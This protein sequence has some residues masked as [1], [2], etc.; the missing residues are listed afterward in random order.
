MK[1][2]LSI[3]FIFLMLAACSNVKGV[4][5][6]EVEERGYITV[7]MEGTW[8]PWTYHDEND[9]LVGFDVE[10]GK[11]IADYL[12]VDVKYVEGE[13]NGLLAG[14]ADGRYDMVINGIDVDEDRKKTYDFSAPYAY[15]RIAVI[16]TKD[17]NSI[18]KMEDLNGKKTA[19]T[20]TSTY[21]KVATQYGASVDG[22]D[23]LNETF[24]LLDSGRIDATLNA[25]MTFLD[26][27]DKNPNANFKIACY[28]DQ[29]PEIA[30]AIRK[31]SDEFVSKVN[32]AINAARADGT[33]S[34]I[35]IKYFG[36]DITNN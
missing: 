35:S 1:K 21:A 5:L 31:N 9:N 22:V 27:M 10:V 34:K 19:N 14:V 20:V 12:G 17:D 7:A 32:E 13:F 4:D 16:T 15:D 8:A 18:T 26:Y 30:V 29:S 2:L 33:L 36:V 23:D 24:M 6:K 25:E 3:L 11:I 28:Y